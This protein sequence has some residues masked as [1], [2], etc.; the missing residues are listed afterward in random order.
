MRPITV[1]GNILAALTIS[2]A[3]EAANPRLERL[4]QQVPELA[5]RVAA[6]EDLL[7]HVSRDGDDLTIAGANLHLV[8]GLGTTQAA[9]GLG[10]LIVGYN[11]L[12]SGTDCGDPANDRSGSHMVVLGSRNNYSAYG[13]FLSGECNLAGAEFSSVLTGFQNTA[14]GPFATVTAGVRSRASGLGASVSGG[15]HQI[16]SGD[17]ASVSGGIQNV[18]SGSSSAVSGGDENQALGLAS[19]VSGGRGRA[20][21][22]PLDWRAGGLSEDE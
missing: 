18:A 8:N 5:A 6:L 11:E 15:S 1:I 12:R 14:S 19:A 7:A 22:G 10:N 20:A 2:G 3:V 21:S 16:A 13:G 9:N 4:E 17:F